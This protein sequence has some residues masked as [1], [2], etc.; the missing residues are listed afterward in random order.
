[1]YLNFEDE[2][3]EGRIRF[4]DITNDITIDEV[5][6]PKIKNVILTR[7]E[8]GVPPNPT[9]IRT[10]NFLLEE[11]KSVRKNYNIIEKFCIEAR[12]KY[13]KDPKKNFKQFMDINLVIGGKFV[14][15]RNEILDTEEGIG[16]F[17]LQ[18]QQLK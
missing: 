6:D 5:E 7:Q 8:R 4:E 14:E 11:I 13:N 17:K 1:M 9:I 2:N 3:N 18:K 10:K 15:G 12:V 16:F